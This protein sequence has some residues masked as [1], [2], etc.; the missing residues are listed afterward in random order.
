MDDFAIELD[1]VLGW[2]HTP[3]QET[4]FELAETMS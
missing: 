1:F 4:L 3:R 2:T